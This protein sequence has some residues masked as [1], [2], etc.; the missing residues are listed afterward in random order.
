MNYNYK[1]NYNELQLQI[2]LQWIWNY[3]YNYNECFIEVDESGTEAAAATVIEMVPLMAPR[4]F[5]VNRPFLF[6]VRD[7]QTKL[8][9]FQGMVTA[10]SEEE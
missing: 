7:L 2:Q 4:E 8:L 3:K 5:V 9:L 10:P 6:Y 1:Y